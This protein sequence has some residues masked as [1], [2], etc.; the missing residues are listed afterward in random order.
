MTDIKEILRKYGYDHA[1]RLSR[2]I[3]LST[4]EK[5]AGYITRHS[6]IDIGREKFDSLR[7]TL[8]SRANILELD[9]YEEYFRLIQVDEEEFK[10]LISLVA[11]NE[12]YFFR[13]PE[14]FDVLKTLVIP[15]IIKR[16][17]EKGERHLRIWSAGCST[18]G[19]AYSIAISLLESIPDR[20]T[21]EISIIG[22]D[23]SEKA[24]ASAREGIYGKNSFRI[25]SDYYK[26]KYFR[27]VSFDKWEI[28]P[29]V[30]KL[31]TFY[32]HNLIKEP[33]PSVLMQMWDIIFC[34]NV[35]IYFK[36]ESTA[37]VIRNFYES[38]VPG[39]Y[40]FTGHSETLY[41]INPGFR[42]RRIGDVFI[43]QK[44]EVEVEQEKPEL[45]LIQEDKPAEQPLNNT[46]ILDCL[47][48]MQNRAGHKE[49]IAEIGKC[50][51]KYPGL[52]NDHEFLKTCG[53]MFLNHGDIDGAW[54]Y[55]EKAAKLNNFDPEVH[56]LAGIYHRKKGHTE[57]AI[58]CFRKAIYLDK[59]HHLSLIELANIYSETGD[60]RK[61]KKY[62]KL[63]A[64]TLK[65]LLNNADV[66]IER[67]KLEL[68]LNICEMMLK[69]AKAREALEE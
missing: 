18:G 40:F 44:P 56:Y 49:A 47:I 59:K 22:T 31:V 28:K 12:T 55:L 2:D 14:Q 67:E 54:R 5:F 15:E 63:A 51:E 9:D 23:V 4:L 24:L 29:F 34:R 68:L 64:E 3:P 19:E 17:N 66:S 1:G 37:R 6:G 13:Y 43:F 52:E 61:A 53:C 62:Y 38:L 39:G 57:K 50:L 20:D 46:E 65:S 42:L 10:E 30:K 58:E 25:T 41:H 26:E 16:K 21:W 45:Q 11:V 69:E 60:Y 48:E 27:K 35:T 7:I 32:F 36:P 8:H 33:Y